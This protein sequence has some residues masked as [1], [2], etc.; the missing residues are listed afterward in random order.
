VAEVAVKEESV[1]PVAVMSA[2]AKLVVASLLVK[3]RVTA[4]VVVLAPLLTVDEVI[5]IVGEVPVYL[6]SVSGCSSSGT[7]FAP[8]VAMPSIGSAR[9]SIT[10]EIAMRFTGDC[11]SGTI[12][13]YRV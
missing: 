8:E 1:Q 11:C 5:V 2:S 9:K 4:E 12:H 7:V 6:D 3:V 10:R 13:P